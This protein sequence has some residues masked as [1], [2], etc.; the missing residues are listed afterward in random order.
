MAE[1]RPITLKDRDVVI[2]FVDK[3]FP[4]GNVKTH[5]RFDS[6]WS[7]KTNRFGYVLEDKGRIVGHMGCIYA[8]RKIADK[9]VL[10]GNMTCWAVESEYRP[11]SLDLLKVL[12]KEEDVVI[13][14]FTPIKEILILLKKFGFKHLDA[15]EDVFYLPA[16][17][18]SGL[19][20]TGSNIKMLH[21]SDLASDSTESNLFQ[22]HL[23]LGC[24]IL[25][26]E[27]GVKAI[28]QKKPLSRGQGAKLVYCDDYELFQ[29]NLFRINLFLAL[30]L[31]TIALIVDKRFASNV[32]TRLKSELKRETFYRP[33][34]ALSDQLP[35]TAVCSLYSETVLK[36]AKEQNALH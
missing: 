15:G 17:F 19:F 33:I 18:L 9:E 11:Q 20:K 13:T 35:A 22:D 14:D 34:S 8:K 25:S 1:I 31:K 26:F 10:F 24:T 21:A 2:A 30:H 6:D 36:Y 3:F 5:L 29:K 32:A 27:N 4:G 7:K 28:F 16:N 12:L 23:K